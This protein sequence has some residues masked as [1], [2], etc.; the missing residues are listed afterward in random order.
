[1]TGNYIHTVSLSPPLAWSP[2]PLGEDPPVLAVA[3]VQRRFQRGPSCGKDVVDAV[4]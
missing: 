3:V 1:M 2:R 4:L